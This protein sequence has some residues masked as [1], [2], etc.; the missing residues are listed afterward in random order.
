M[1]GMGPLG[2]PTAGDFYLY[3][4]LDLMIVAGLV[5]LALSWKLGLPGLNSG[6]L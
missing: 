3:L 4:T 1:P 5:W 6:G 2:T